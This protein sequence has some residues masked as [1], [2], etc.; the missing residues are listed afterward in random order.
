MCDQDLRRLQA[1]D[2]LII[3]AIKVFKYIF[4][5]FVI[6][7]SSSC[8]STIYF[9]ISPWAW[10]WWNA[11]FWW[12]GVRLSAPSVRTCDR[13][14]NRGE[15]TEFIWLAIISFE[16]MIFEF[17]SNFKNLLHFLTD[18][19]TKIRFSHPIWIS[20]LFW[21]LIAPVLDAEVNWKIPWRAKCS[22]LFVRPRILQ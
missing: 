14:F 18:S 7:L 10:K 2:R 21:N 6:N 13:W 8:T 9:I 4:Q 11:Y 16:V 3:R 5:F 17:S 22:R 1:S 20:Q 19:I 12:L 15:R